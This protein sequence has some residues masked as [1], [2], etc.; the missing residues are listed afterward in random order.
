MTLRP[1]LSTGTTSWPETSRTW[2]RSARCQGDVD[3][4]VRQLEL[5]QHLAY[6]V[7]VRA[8]FGLVEREHAHLVS[9]LVSVTVRL[10]EPRRD[11]SPR[12]SLPSARYYSRPQT[13][14]KARPT[15]PSSVVA[16]AGCS[17]APGGDRCVGRSAAGFARA[18]R[19]RLRLAQTRAGLRG[20]TPERAGSGQDAGQADEG[21][22]AFR[23]R[24]RSPRGRS[25]RR[26]RRDRGAAR[27]A[28][29]RRR[30]GRRAA[31]RRPAR[32]RGARRPRCGSDARRSA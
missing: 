14:G 30:A 27:S 5:G 17:R 3:A 13:D 16:L 25:L 15:R 4:G 12:P 11:R 20:A 10:G 1:S 21:R 22:R 26:R 8:P 28:A 29:V 18:S 7:A 9:C 19:R 31:A 32:R 23:R 6:P 2:V 24:P